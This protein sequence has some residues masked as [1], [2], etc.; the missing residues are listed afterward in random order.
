MRIKLDKEDQRNFKHIITAYIIL[1][2]IGYVVAGG[3]IWTDSAQLTLNQSVQALDNMSVDVTLFT[4]TIED[5]GAGSVSFSSDIELAGND[6]K[7]SGGIAFKPNAEA[8]DFLTYSVP[9]SGYLAQENVFEP[10]GGDQKINFIGGTGNSQV[11]IRPVHGSLG[12]LQFVINK[13]ETQGYCSFYIADGQGG[14]ILGCDNTPDYLSFYPSSDNTHSNG[15][16]GNRWSDVQSVLIQGSDIC[17]ENDICFTE[18]S[19]DGKKDICFI[20]EKPTEDMRKTIGLAGIDSYTEYVQSHTTIDGYDNSMSEEEYNT[21]EAS[22][23]VDGQ[24]DLLLGRTSYGSL[25]QI[26]DNII[27]QNQRLNA[28]ETFLCGQGASQ[29][30]EG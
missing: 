25:R 28:I 14:L 23:I 26:R 3:S 5:N 6:I 21:R 4:D 10:A 24:M 8:V 7:S 22:I 2:F 1:G 30:C 11:V 16:A 19:V 17:F 12:I 15:I 29:F 20:A 13:T 18:C 27:E 9:Q